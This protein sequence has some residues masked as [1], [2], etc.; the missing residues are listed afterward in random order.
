MSIR[1]QLLRWLL[2]ALVLAG[3]VT[4]ALTFV[5]AR[6]EVSEQ[7]D[8]QLHH[9]AYAYDMSG[10]HPAPVLPRLRDADPE[11]RYALLIRDEDGKLLFA[12]PGAPELPRISVQGF[13]DA[14]LPSGEWRVF[15][16]LENGRSLQLAQRRI[17]RDEVAADSALYAS[18]PVFLL[19]PLLGVLTFW[20]IGRSLGGLR[21]TI[22][23]VSDRDAE[24]LAPLPMEDVPEEIAPLVAEMN[25]L[26]SRLG[27][28]IEAQRRFVSDA[29]HELRTPLA[30]L[31]L[32]S[33]NLQ[34]VENEADR[35]ERLA[36]LQ[37]G[38]RRASGLV[39]QL[40]R[41]ARQ[42]ARQGEAARERVALGELLR[43]CLSELAPLAVRKGIDLGLFMDEAD[44][45][46]S[47]AGDREALRVLFSNLIENALRYTPEGGLV[48]VRLSPSPEGT[49]VEVADSGP[50]IPEE[51][52]ERVFDRFFRI[53]G[54]SEEGSGLG[55]SL[56]RRIAERHGASVRLANRSTGGLAARVLFR[57]EAAAAPHA[58]KT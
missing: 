42:E 16:R 11:E 14:A 47:V 52:L 10:A 15:T 29:A 13:S 17:V 5:L 53:E 22:A 58:S 6:E 20:A 21:E 39:D 27:E 41:M 45:A 12:S 2:G 30:A 26:L 35:Q 32:Q 40:L 34:R 54:T 57:A 18:L 4:G 50:G 37:A 28:A 19:V 36:A 55:L 38:I 1:R 23:A 48:D 25:A 43:E 9:L 24:N 46:Q 33:F 49:R 56:V 44:A 3:L 8:S 51:L 31:Q 7:L